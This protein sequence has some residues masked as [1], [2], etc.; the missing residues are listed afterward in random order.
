MSAL[1]K[2]VSHPAG[3]DLLPGRLVHA[4]GHVDEEV[5]RW[6][7]RPAYQPVNDPI[8]HMAGPVRPEEAGSR[9]T[10]SVLL[11]LIDHELLGRRD[12]LQEPVRMLDR[13]QLVA[14]A[15]YDE[16]GAAEPRP[17]PLQGEPLG[18]AVEFGLVVVTG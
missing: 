3:S 13:A 5:S 1:S 14:L 2:S 4:T 15:C 12:L 10:Q 6:C 7:L 17:H 18:E 16:I 11:A 8:R 9:R